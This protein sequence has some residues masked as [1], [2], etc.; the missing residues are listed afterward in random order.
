MSRPEHYYRELDQQ[1]FA[2]ADRAEL[3]RQRYLSK[4][5]LE[6][7]EDRAQITCADYCDAYKLQYDLDNAF[8]SFCNSA[9][10]DATGGDDDALAFHLYSHLDPDGR[11]AR[12]TVAEAGRVALELRNN[13]D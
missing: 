10:I 5:N 2:A 13:A 7:S 1:F 6:D 8:Q 11:D 3:Q 9:V 12:I 4:L